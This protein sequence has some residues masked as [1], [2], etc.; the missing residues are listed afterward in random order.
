[1]C[2]CNSQNNDSNNN[3]QNF[4]IITVDVRRKL[5]TEWQR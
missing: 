2:V 3:T 4:V 1:M 5:G